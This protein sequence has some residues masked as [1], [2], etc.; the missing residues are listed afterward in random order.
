V[1]EGILELSNDDAI[2]LSSAGWSEVY[3]ELDF[4][5]TFAKYGVREAELANTAKSTSCLVFQ[6]MIDPSFADLRPFRREDDMYVGAYNSWALAFDNISRRGTLCLYRRARERQS[7]SN[8]HLGA[9]RILSVTRG[10][11]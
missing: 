1:L 10:S 4:D 8:Q 9:A 2:V 11:R 5:P 3:S 6:R 7:D